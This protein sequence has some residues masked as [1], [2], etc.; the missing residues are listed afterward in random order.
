M[1]VVENQILDQARGIEAFCDYEW[2]LGKAINDVLSKA[3]LNERYIVLEDG[4]LNVLGAG[5]ITMEK[6]R[7]FIEFPLAISATAAEI[8]R[9]K[10]D[11]QFLVSSMSKASLSALVKGGVFVYRGRSEECDLFD[12]CVEGEE[13]LFK[14]YKVEVYGKDEENI[15]FQLYNEEGVPELSI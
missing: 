4:N 9:K 10:K 13:N 3:N 14:D 12:I 1:S 11:E 6:A 5:I 2:S 8:Y 15:Y 7:K